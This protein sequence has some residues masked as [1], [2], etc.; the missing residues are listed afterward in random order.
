MATMREG[1]PPLPA[2]LAHLPISPEGYP[3]PWFVA[4]VN[5]VPDFRCSEASKVVRAVQEDLCFMCGTRNGAFKVFPIGPMCAVNRVTSEPPEELPAG[6]VEVEVAVEVQ[7][8][9]GPQSR[10]RVAGLCDSGGP[11]ELDDQRAGELGQSPVQLRDLR[12]VDLLAR[13][14]RRDRG[15]YDVR[16][17]TAQRDCSVE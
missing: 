15:L 14:Q 16:A 1:L 6:R 17:A 4:W 8:V 9:D 7:A 11:V 12:P 5:G 13:L 3:V 10:K 2:R